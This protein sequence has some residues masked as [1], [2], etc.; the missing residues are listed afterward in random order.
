MCTAEIGEDREKKKAITCSGECAKK[1]KSH[2]RK[3]KDVKACRQC[4]KPSTIEERILF[5]QWRREKFPKR[6]Q[7]RPKKEQPAPAEAQA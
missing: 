4:G 5:Q 1:L 2:R 3:T 7:G 6:K